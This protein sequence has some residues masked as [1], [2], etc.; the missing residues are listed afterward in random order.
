MSD[1]MKRYNLILPQDLYDCVK[2]TADAK[3]TSVVEV[4][5]QFIRLGLL[6]TKLEN[7]SDVKIIIQ[8]GDSQRELILL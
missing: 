1:E 7:S 2:E 6:V 3:H 5:R 4:L 8:E